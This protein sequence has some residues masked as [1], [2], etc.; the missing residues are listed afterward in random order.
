MDPC[1]E[2]QRLLSPDDADACWR[3]GPTVPLPPLGGLWRDKGRLA[4]VS[5]PG[6]PPLHVGREAPEAAADPRAAPAPPFP[7][8]LQ[9]DTPPRP[10]QRPHIYRETHGSQPGGEVLGGVPAR[11]HTLSW[12][13]AVSRSVCWSRAGPGGATRPGDRLAGQ[14]AWPGPPSPRAGRPWRSRRRRRP[15]EATRRR[16][17]EP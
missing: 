15:R 2:N 11:G 13:A 6:E 4:S 3:P 5:G 12:G 1:E 17:G 8:G 16:P 9:K 7:L 10:R 14:Q